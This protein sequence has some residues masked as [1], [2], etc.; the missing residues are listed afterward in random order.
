MKTFLY[1]AAHGCGMIFLV[2]FV[3]FLV[4]FLYQQS[5]QNR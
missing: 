5:Q 4:A 1:E 3:I 2:L